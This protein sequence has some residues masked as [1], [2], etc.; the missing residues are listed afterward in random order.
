[1]FLAINGHVNPR[2]ELQTTINALF[3]PVI[4]NNPNIHVICDNEL[5]WLGERQV[6]SISVIY[7]DSY[8]GNPAAFYRHILFKV[9]SNKDKQT[10]ELLNN[11]L[12]FDA[13]VPDNEN[14]VAYIS[15]G[16]IGGYQAIT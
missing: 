4:N 12:N 5:Q 11:S 14:P 1:L 6:K 3:S 15:K 10:N 16:L 8:L 13:Q 9:D 2:A 7:A